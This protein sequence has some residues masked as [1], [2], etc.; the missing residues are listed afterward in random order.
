MYGLHNTRQMFEAKQNFFF[1]FSKPQFR[2]FHVA[3][4]I[5]PPFL[6]IRRM[7]GLWEFFT[8]FRSKSFLGET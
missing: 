8:Q 3:K 6:D 1:D 5:L 2:D 7:R 4:D